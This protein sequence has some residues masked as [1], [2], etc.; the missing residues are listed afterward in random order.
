MRSCVDPRRNAFDLSRFPTACR[1]ICRIGLEFKN[2]FAIAEQNLVLRV[3]RKSRVW[4]SLN[5]SSSLVE[6]GSQS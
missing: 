1:V 4:Q 5:D 6:K 3:D 2:L